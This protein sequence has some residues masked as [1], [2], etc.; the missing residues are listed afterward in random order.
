MWDL[1]CIASALCFLA[2][3][4]LFLVRG[5]LAAYANAH[6]QS[7]MA[8]NN[9]DASSSVASGGTNAGM[10]YNYEYW[11]QLDPT[12]VQYKWMERE[13]HRPLVISASVR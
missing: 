7:V 2:S 1:K 9:G 5:Y 8:D 4:V 3:N 12:Y 6:A 11:K 13:S 10:E